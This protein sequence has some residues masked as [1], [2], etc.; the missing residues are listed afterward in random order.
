MCKALL[1]IRK[2]LGFAFER[3]DTKNAFRSP[4][5]T[6]KHCRKTRPFCPK[7]RQRTLPNASQILCRA[8]NSELVKVLSITNTK[9]H[10]KRQRQK[11]PRRD[12]G[13]NKEGNWHHTGCH[14]QMKAEKSLARSTI[15]NLVVHAQT[16]EEDGKLTEQWK[17][18]CGCT[19][20]RFSTRTQVDGWAGFPLPH[21]NV[22]SSPCLLIPV[23][24]LS[25]NTCYKS[26]L[27]S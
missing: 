19:E 26:F 3:G 13:G 25:L 21:T 14:A 7:Q 23:V 15:S 22:F 2:L 10:S 27:S 17:L 18:L 6:T 11:K 12:T 20:S 1:I 5:K 24:F 16:K 4:Y 8:S 9:Q